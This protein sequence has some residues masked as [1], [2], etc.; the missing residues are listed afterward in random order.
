MDSDLPILEYLIN[1]NTN[2]GKSGIQHWTCN[3]SINTDSNLL[4][5]EDLFLNTN[6]EK[7]SIQHSL[8]LNFLCLLTLIIHD[9]EFHFDL[10]H[11]FEP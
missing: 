5:L 3:W 8:I 1:Y 6:I 10:H 2:T 11:F 7:T 9:Q 4:I